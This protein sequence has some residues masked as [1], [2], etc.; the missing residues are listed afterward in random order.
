[1]KDF[2]KNKV[3]ISTRPLKS[4]N[5][6]DELLIQAGGQVE[7]L[8]MI[9]IVPNELNAAE[10]ALLNTIDHFNWIVFTS[11]NGVSHFFNKLDSSS[12]LAHIRFAVI[13]KKT[14]QVLNE[15]GYQASFVNPGNTSDEFAVAFRDFM[16]AQEPNAKVLFVLGNLAGSKIEDQLEG[17]AH[18]QRIDIYKTIQPE[19]VDPSVLVKI[20]NDQYDLLIFTSPSAFKNILELVPELAPKDLRTACIGATTA[21]YIRKHGIEPLAIAENSTAVG[22][23]DS[24]I[25]YYLSKSPK[26]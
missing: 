17:V 24:I 16:K 10:K 3:F 14:E 21:K 5:E 4:K 15:F 26:N 20:K 22:I 2:L 18:F 23:Y 12:N 7:Y 9:D 13:G 25:N 8:P 11:N 1:M 6:L 19:F